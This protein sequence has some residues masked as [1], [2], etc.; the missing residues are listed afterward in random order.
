M[1]A[2]N[3]QFRCGTLHKPEVFFLS[4]DDKSVPPLGAK[5]KNRKMVIESS[6]SLD[7][8]AQHHGEVGAI[9]E[10]EILIAIGEPVCQAVSRSAVPTISMVAPPLRKPSQKSSA[11]RR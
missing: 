11:A 6:R 8:Q 10:R 9:N 5:P 1:A 2:K 7:P 4:N 3:A